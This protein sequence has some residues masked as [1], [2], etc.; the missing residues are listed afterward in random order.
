MNVRYLLKSWENWKIW[1][2]KYRKKVLPHILRK[3]GV[4]IVDEE[5]DNLIILDACR[6][7]MFKRYNNIKGK[8]E[9]RISRG[10]C[11]PEFLLENFDKH[12]NRKKF[13]DIVYVSANPFVSKL[14]PNKFYKI[15]PTWDYGWDHELNTVPPE[16]VVKDSLRAHKENP[17]KRL[18]IHFV[19]PHY[20]F[21]T[22]KLIGTGFRRLRKSVL[23]NKNGLYDVNPWFLVERGQIPIRIMVK[24]YVEN[25][26]IVLRSVKSLINQLS[27]KTVITSDHGE[28]FGERPHILYPFKAYEHPP[29]FYVKSLV[30]VPWLIINE[31]AKSK[32]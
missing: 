25:L 17:H 6:Y 22:V 19:Q 31:K 9:F 32:T 29:R 4:Y 10:S 30:K 1:R 26:K 8:L 3:R 15:Y 23:E 16:N 27:G 18:I 24:G 12:P 11:T 14:L 13:K 2:D 28:L 5:W 20:P 7:D 21:L